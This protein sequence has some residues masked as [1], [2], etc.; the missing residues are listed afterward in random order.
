MT[1]HLH[2]SFRTGL[3]GLLALGLFFCAFEF[4]QA[5]GPR[6]PIPTSFHSRLGRVP[7]DH[8]EK[9][10]ASHMLRW[11]AKKS[12]FAPQ[13]DMGL[14]L[15]AQQ[16]AGGLARGR[17]RRLSHKQVVPALW[18]FG[19]SDHQIRV[20]AM[21]FR[22]T[23]ELTDALERAL[24]SHLAQHRPNFFGLA[25]VSRK[26]KIGL[27]LF[28]RRGALLEQG[29]R[30]C[31]VGQMCRLSG[32]LMQGKVRP[33]VMIGNPHGKVL[34]P[35][36]K[37]SGR[38]AFAVEWPVRWSGPM[39]VQVM[40]TDQ[41]GPWIT[42]QYE[43]HGWEPPTSR[44]GLLR[45]V[46][47][48]YLRAATLSSPP[49]QRKPS[50]R[51]PA[52]RPTRKTP[53][54]AQ[55]MAKDLWQNVNAFRRKQSLSFLR[56]HPT[57]D[58]LAQSHANDMATYHYFAHTS[59]RH[60]SF[61]DRFQRLGWTVKIAQENIV[62]ARSPKEALRHWMESPSHRSNLIEPKF[63]WTGVGAAVG[64]DGQIYFV[65]VYIAK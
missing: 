28:S 44:G 13:L 38:N 14:R 35:K 3:L 7:L 57:L 30:L 61:A 9:P 34:R 22:Q 10:I 63:R 59:P 36:V 32:Y 17:I 11:F 5:S 50:K 29:S 52:V 54:T 62:A 27:L 21:A 16:L 31:R 56:R 6:I 15:A 39:Q 20:F 42:A 65:Q 33:L 4:V 24:A 58:A 64:K 55:N 51:H 46:V 23:H 12:K 26:V 8:D 60:G 37:R 25:V 18:L 47:Q 53:Q 40:V 48:G 1:P 2:V 41:D 19:R 45:H 49:S 43:I